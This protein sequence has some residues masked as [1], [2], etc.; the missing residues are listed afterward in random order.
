MLTRRQPIILDDVPSDPRIPR[1]YEFREAELKSAVLLPILLTGKMVA[2]ACAYTVH[3]YRRF[4]QEEIALAKGMGNILGLGIRNAQLYEKSKLLMVMEERARLSREIHDGIAQTLGALQLKASQLQDSVA[5]N[6]V[7]EWEYYLPEVQDMISRAYSDLR[8]AMMGLRAVVEPGAGL[9]A[10]LK[11]YLTHYQPEYGVSVS[12]EVSEGDPVM[13]DGVAQAQAVRIVQ[14]ALSNVRRHS[15]VNAA[16]VRIERRGDAVRI[17]VVDGGRGFDA[18]LLERRERGT[19]LGLRTMAERAAS[20]GGALAV[21]SAPGFGTRVVLD[22][23]LP[24]GE[25]EA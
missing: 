10:A 23:P 22:L 7:G 24:G 3:D 13:L 25:G 8:E 9:V 1:D 18:A 4:T 16:S 17:S 19:H 12:L 20:V 21:D 14:E 6:R 15:G 2:L 5:N 11:E